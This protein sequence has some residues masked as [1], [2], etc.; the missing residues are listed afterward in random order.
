MSLN[1]STLTR[2]YFLL[3]DDNLRDGLIGSSIN[4]QKVDSRA[5]CFC[6]DKV[7]IRVS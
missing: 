1:H 6:V 2:S 4:N 3:F 5:E 7:H